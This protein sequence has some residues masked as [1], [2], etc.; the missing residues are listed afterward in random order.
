MKRDAFLALSVLAPAHL[1]LCN[2]EVT[3]AALLPPDRRSKAD[4]TRRRGQQ[5]PMGGVYLL[6]GQS[7]HF[8]AT[9]WAAEHRPAQMPICLYDIDHALFD[10]IQLG[11]QTHIFHNIVA[12]S[13]LVK[14]SGNT[15]G[16]RAQ[17][18]NHAINS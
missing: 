12:V 16:K 6:Q 8:P 15:L 5:P 13:L 7:D 10:C 2:P 14:D 4:D 9:A 17:P 3:A 1:T 18:T 11:R